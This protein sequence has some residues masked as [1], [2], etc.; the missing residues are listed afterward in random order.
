MI[1]FTFK[2]TSCVAI[3]TFNI[4]I[5]QPRLLKEMGVIEVGTPVLVAGDLAQPGIRFEVANSTWFVRPDRLS[6]ESNL[7]TVDCG[8]YVRRTCE[9]LC[10]TPIMAAGINVQFEAPLTEEPVLPDAFRLPACE[11][12]IQRTVHWCVPD[13]DSKVNIQIVAAERKLSIVVNR[14]MD[15][16]EFRHVPRQLTKK[17]QE[18]CGSFVRS[19]DASIEIAKNLVNGDFVYERNDVES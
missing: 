3:G 6:V 8:D 10:W 9:T 15:F 5:V 17:V 1:R 4:H 7:P 2:H 14:H 13:G 11:N 18:F 19:R 12:A 16:S